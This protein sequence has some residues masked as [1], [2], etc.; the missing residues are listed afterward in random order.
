LEYCIQNNTISSDYLKSNINGNP[1]PAIKLYRRELG[2]QEF[3][4]DVSLIG[5]PGGTLKYGIMSYTTQYPVYAEDFPTPVNPTQTQSP[6]NM[7]Q[8]RISPAISFDENLEDEYNENNN[9]DNLDDLEEE[10]Y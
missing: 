1:D 8:S 2:S 5:R 7:M 4:V 3:N 9:I 6:Y 10:D